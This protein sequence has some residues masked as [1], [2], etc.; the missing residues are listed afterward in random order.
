MKSDYFYVK[1]CYEKADGNRKKDRKIR[2]RVLGGQKLHG[3]NMDVT[4]NVSCRHDIR[5]EYPIGSI[6]CADEIIFRPTTEKIKVP[7]FKVPN[8][9]LTPMEV[10]GEIV[11]KNSWK[12]KDYEDILP[13]MINEERRLKLEWVLSE[14]DCPLFGD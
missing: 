10:N 1:T 14:D 7:F 9:K 4:L 11:C 8:N 12:V 2:V 6:F 3:Q 13:Y 5:E